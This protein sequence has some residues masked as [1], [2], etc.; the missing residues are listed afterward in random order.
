VSTGVAEIPHDLDVRARR[1]LGRSSDPIYEMVARV[2]RTRGVTGERL[3]DVGCGAGGLWPFVRDRFTTYCGL[4]ALRYEGF[5]AEGHF[6]S[7]DLDGDAWWGSFSPGDVVA[8]IETIEHLEN[9]WSFMRGL[10]ALVKPGGWVVVSTP[11]QLSALSL[12]TLLVKGRFSA[13]QDVHYPVHR[14]SLLEVDLAR[15]A[16]ASGFR[17]VDIAYSL[18][19]RLP[20][21]A[22]HY[23]SPAARTWPR[24]LSD[25][26]A[27]LARRPHA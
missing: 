10:Y 19:G 11:N 6:H 3:I 2:L 14:T 22:R 21:S 4:D 27:L 1:S 8:A 15:A 12:L 26:L 9:P 5:P 16:A 18:S 25:N 7:A 24:R 20:L 23:P 17:V 13:F